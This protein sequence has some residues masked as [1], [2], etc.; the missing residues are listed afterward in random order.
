MCRL[1]PGR[2]ARRFVRRQD[3]AAAIEFALVAAPFLALT[4]AILE[5][6]MV[7][8]G[9]QMLQSAA[10]DAARKIMTGQAMTTNFDTGAP[11]PAGFSKANF[12]SEVCR[13]LTGM[14]DCGKVLVDV[15]VYAT[16][17]AVTSAPPIAPDGTLDDS[18]TNY[19]RGDVGNI[20][21]V[22]IYYPWPIYVS[23]L[24]LLASNSLAGSNR[25][26]VATS[27]FRVEPFH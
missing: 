22:S 4:F 13:H 23:Q 6:A 11:D 25:L 17:A 20:V 18:R 8:F 7:F 16:F 19:N 14:F 3:G 26:L 5:T 9:G 10:S 24:D 15:Q 1:V 27:V 12:K 2:I 21:A